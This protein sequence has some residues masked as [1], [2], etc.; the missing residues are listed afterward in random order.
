MEILGIHFSDYV[1]YKSLILCVLAFIGGML[2]FTVDFPNTPPA[3]HEKLLNPEAEPV[4][5]PEAEQPRLK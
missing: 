3:P 2:G 5:L 1:I 4:C